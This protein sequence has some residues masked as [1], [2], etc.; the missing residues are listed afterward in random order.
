MTLFIALFCGISFGI[1][2]TISQM[3]NPNKVL[4]FLDITGNW[5]PSLVL[6]MFSALTLFIPV[7]HKIIKNKP[8]P[9]FTNAFSL[10]SKITI[11]YPLLFG[12]SIF[13]IGWGISGICPGPALVNMTQGSPKIIVFILL[14]L[15]GMNIPKYVN[16]LLSR[17][18]K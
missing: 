13:G 5:D 4:N 16:M 3:V 12:A 14:M 2:L 1:G 7:Y 17:L 10:P 8:K 11:D 9:T 15:I 6:V 18:N